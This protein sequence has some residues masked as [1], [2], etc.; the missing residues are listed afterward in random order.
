MWLF[1]LHNT[2][3][4]RH[5]SQLSHWRNPWLRH[6]VGYSFGTSRKKAATIFYDTASFFLVNSMPEAFHWFFIWKG[7]Y[8]K[9]LIFASRNSKQKMNRRPQSRFFQWK[10]YGTHYSFNIFKYINKI[11]KKSFGIGIWRNAIA[12]DC[13]GHGLS[14]R[15]SLP[16]VPFF[17]SSPWACLILLTIRL[18]NL[19]FWGWIAG[20]VPAKISQEDS[21]VWTNHQ[22]WISCRNP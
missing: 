1:H 10:H 17:Q 20:C 7:C 15:L 19:F 14:E 2:V 6:L 11:S 5:F 22:S 18:A 13:C 21:H 9:R 3:K 12:A 16:H 4:I 8:N